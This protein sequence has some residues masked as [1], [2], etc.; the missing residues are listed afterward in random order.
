DEQIGK[1]N[2]RRDGYKI[3]LGIVGEL[4]VERRI[5][6]VC[7]DRPERE[8]VAVGRRL[9]DNAGA[10]AAARPAL[11]LDD[12]RYAVFRLKMLAKYASDQIRRASGQE[13]NDDGDGALGPCVLAARNVRRQYEC[14]CRGCKKMASVHYF[15]SN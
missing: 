12:D 5:D 15:L 3:S 9:G 13:W 10:D 11:V 14:R 2:E 7:A 1:A 6:G 4:A 8:R